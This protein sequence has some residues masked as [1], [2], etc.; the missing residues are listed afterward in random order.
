VDLGLPDTSGL[1][2]VAAVAA[3]RP[4]TGVLVL[5]SYDERPPRVRRPA[6][7]CAR[8]LAK[9]ASADELLRA[10]HTVAGGAGTFSPT[11]VRRIT[12][13]SP[14]AAGRA[15]PTVP[16]AVAARARRARADGRWAQQGL[17]RRHFVLSLKTVRNHVSTVLTKIGA[18]SR[19]EAVALARDAGLAAP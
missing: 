1:G 6:G 8:Y 5:T 14:P 11:V 2:V 4:A 18:R 16:R 19:A 13:M 9:T 10:V 12:G 17:H 7:R 3:A 15:L